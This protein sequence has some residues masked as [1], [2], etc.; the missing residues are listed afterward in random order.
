MG[1]VVPFPCGAW[2]LCEEA[3]E[4]HE[5]EL[6]VNRDLVHLRMLPRGGGLSLSSE[7][8]GSAVSERGGTF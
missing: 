4:E 8:P 7:V 6:Q 2:G 3:V 5:G 1:M